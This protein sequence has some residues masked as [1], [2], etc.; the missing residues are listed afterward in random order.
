M[1]IILRI[2]AIQRMFER[3]ISAADIRA[4]LEYGETIENYPDDTH[5]PGRLV[6]GWHGKRLLHVV[7]ADNPAENAHII[8]TVYEPDPTQ[9][10]SD[11]KR[12]T[13]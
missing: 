1:K 7:V 4:V 3:S 5:Y 8:I 10:T 6:L 11:F 2:H 13:R 9:W 12:R